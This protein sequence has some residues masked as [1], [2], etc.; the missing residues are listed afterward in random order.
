MIFFCNRKQEP[1]ALI[2]F[3]QPSILLACLR[4]REYELHYAANL[5]KL[6]K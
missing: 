1:E 5:T 2:L 4:P 6:N 3:L